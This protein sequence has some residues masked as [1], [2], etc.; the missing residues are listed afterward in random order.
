MNINIAAEIARQIKKL[1]RNIREPWNEINNLILRLDGNHNRLKGKDI[2]IKSY[3][4]YDIINELAEEIENELV[5][6]DIQQ[7]KEIKM[8]YYM[9]SC[10]IG[11]IDYSALVLADSRKEAENITIRN[12]VDS[13]D[14]QELS[15]WEFEEL[16][17]DF[18]LDKKQ[19][20]KELEKN[21]YFLYDSGT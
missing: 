5:E 20:E 4:I 2:K 10:N 12:I 7:E 15:L 21:K 9:V 13:L 6:Q 11:R 1:A 19:V 17:K 8:E 14:A 3:E 18:E 16:I